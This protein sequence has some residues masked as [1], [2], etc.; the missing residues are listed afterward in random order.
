MT[1]LLLLKHFNSSSE[2]DWIL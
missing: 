2:P 1:L